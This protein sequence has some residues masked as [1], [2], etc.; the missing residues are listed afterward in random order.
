MKLFIFLSFLTVFSLK[1]YSHDYYFAF[2]EME[3]NEKSNKLE[4]TLIIN[5]HD[6]EHWLK[7][8]KFNLLDTENKTLND[9][10]QVILSN[11][12]LSGFSVQ[13][14]TIQLKLDFKGI[15]VKKD[16]NIEFYFESETIRNTD[17]VK[18]TFDLLMNEYEQQ[19]NKLIYIKDLNRKTF[20]FLPSKTSYLV[21]L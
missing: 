15:L 5:N 11:K 2:A 21:K 13:Q 6:V 1:S 16:G 4:L 12:I 8:T 19:Q 9:S 20:E 18:V 7:N 17:E 3:I 10:L 14:S